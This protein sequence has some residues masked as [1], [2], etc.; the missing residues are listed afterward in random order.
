MQII[1][2]GTILHYLNT[3]TM[4]PFFT[5]SLVDGATNIFGQASAN[6]QNQQLAE[7][8]ANWNL[9]AQQNQQ[10]FDLEMWER[11][12]LYNSPIEQMARFKEAGLNPHLIYGK[13]TPGNAMPLR[14]PDVKP[15]DRAQMDSVTRGLSVFGDHFKFK[16]LQAQTN[17]TEANT[18]VQMQEAALKGAQT[19][20]S[21]MRTARGA[22]DLK[23]AKDLRQNSIDAAVAGLD[24]AKAKA[25]EAT[26]RAN[27]SDRQQEA[28]LNLRRTEIANKLKDGKIKDAQVAVNELDAELAKERIRPGDPLYYRIMGPF[29]KYIL[30]PSKIHMD[31]YKFFINPENK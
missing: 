15:Y 5:A 28:T 6:N 20:E 4:D 17:N 30:N 9:Q 24:E 29:L 23:L 21:A 2:R 11:A 25:R 14:S 12:N 26:S 3:N 22:F 1:T 27:Y 10:A 16:N 7:Q 19:A 18:S 8:Q 31:A 13:G